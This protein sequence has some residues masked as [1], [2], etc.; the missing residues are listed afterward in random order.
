MKETFCHQTA[1]RASAIFVFAEMTEANVGVFDEA[2]D[3]LVMLRTMGCCST[4]SEFL[5]F[6]LS[7]IKSLFKF[8][9]VR[10]SVAS[11]AL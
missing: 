6:T 2:R 9:R 5:R 1:T 8:V 3:S 11:L 4:S 7:W 10:V